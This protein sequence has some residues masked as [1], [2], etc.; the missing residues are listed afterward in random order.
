MYSLLYYCLGFQADWSQTYSGLLC[1]RFGAAC[2]TIAYGGKC[3]MR[4]GNCGG[5]P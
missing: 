5:E 1:H 2:S 3:M 4:E